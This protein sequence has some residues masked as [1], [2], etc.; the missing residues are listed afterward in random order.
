VHALADLKRALEEKPVSRPEFHY[1]TYID[2][3]PEAL[4][5]ALTDPA[6]TKRYWGAE[7]KS[8]WEPGSPVLWREGGD[9][10]H[11]W[12]QVV[13]EAKPYERLSY[14]W[15]NYQESFAEYFGWSAERLAELRQEKI[16]K[17]TFE[18]EQADSA[19]KLTV[20]H[21]DFEGDTEMLQGISAGW[22][23][24]LSKLKTLLETGKVMDGDV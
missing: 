1:V 6:F 15:H 21:D 17:V 19:V 24:I 8:D 23:L 12:D 20:L 13:L 10:F 3:T 14:T 16:S 18:I 7:L 22:P 5:Q 2:T 11:D 9:E 4:W